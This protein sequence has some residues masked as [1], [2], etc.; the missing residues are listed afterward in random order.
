MKENKKRF[1]GF[2]GFVIGLVLGVVVCVGG[3]FYTGHLVTNTE[4]A[5]ISY[6]TIAGFTFQ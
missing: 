2:K 1:S 3:L 4:V 5:T 6:Q